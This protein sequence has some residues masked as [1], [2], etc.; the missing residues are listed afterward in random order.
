MGVGKMLVQK[1]LGE[2]RDHYTKRSNSDWEGQ[3]SSDITSMWNLIGKN[4][5]NELVYKTETDL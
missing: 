3:I 4:D 1:H 5:T 2:F